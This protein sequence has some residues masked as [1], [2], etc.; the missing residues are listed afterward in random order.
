MFKQPSFAQTLATTVLGFLFSTV[1]CQPTPTSAIDPS[2][3]AY[4]LSTRPLP[5][6][7]G[8][9]EAFHRAGQSFLTW[10]ELRRIL[11]SFGVAEDPSRGFL[12]STGRIINCLLYTS[13]AADE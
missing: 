12:P 11:R 10:P 5:D 3:G 2:P 1:A 6:S 8:R 4:A 13:D 7:A 9:L